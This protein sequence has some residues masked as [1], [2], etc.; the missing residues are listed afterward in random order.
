MGVGA[1]S[2]GDL[3]IRA[4]PGRGVR[5]R[6]TSMSHCRRP[7]GRWPPTPSSTRCE[8]ST[9]SR[10]SWSSDRPR[11][12]IPVTSALDTLESVIDRHPDPLTLLGLRA[13]R[14]TDASVSFP[15]MPPGSGNTPLRP[16]SSSSTC[17]QGSRL[18]DVGAGITPLAPFLTSRGYVIDTVDPSD[19]HRRGLRRR[20]GTSGDS[21]TT[22]K[23]GWVT[24]RGIAPWASCRSRPCSTEPCPSAS[25][26]TFL[27]PR[28]GHF[29]RTLLC[30]C[31]RVAS[32][33]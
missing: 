27:R 32:W 4:R 22:Q 9:G 23:P 10:H 30:A 31:V 11:A 29:S 20:T 14:A 1:T 12:H 24:D 19:I 17:R 8:R 28:D 13:R 21:S 6:A 2:A 33:C 18:V 26:S 15:I 7:C 16:T 3:G 25:S 5:R